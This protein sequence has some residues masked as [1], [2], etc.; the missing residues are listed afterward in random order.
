MTVLRRTSALT[1]L[2]LLWGASACDRSPA[3]ELTAEPRASA[4]NS[5]VDAPAV[6]VP[7]AAAPDAAAPAV[8]IVEP[9]G[10]TGGIAR[11]GWFCAFAPLSS[12]RF[13][14]RA[15]RNRRLT[16][17]I[18]V[19]SATKRAHRRKRQGHSRPAAEGQALQLRGRGRHLATRHRIRLARGAL[20]R[21][22]RVAT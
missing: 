8:V 1:L 3:P 21:A 4:T 14:R 7:A 12:E 9:I 20:A 17:T 22:D 18:R 10:A 11:D 6:A 13:R 2:G 19:P 16:R 5:A 15:S